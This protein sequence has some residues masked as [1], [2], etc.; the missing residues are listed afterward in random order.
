[1]G[2]CSAYLCHNKSTKNPDK[3]YFVLPKDPKI[4]NAWIKA[5][6]RTELPKNVC[7]CSDHFED[8]CFDKSWELQNRLFYQGR[9]QKRKLLPGSIP[10]IFP[11]KEKQAERS[12][13]KLRAK[14]KESFQ[15]CIYSKTTYSPGPFL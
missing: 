6:N 14:K 12:I 15:V 1:M 9:I 4:R 10:T 5:I 2:C 13:S 11:H 7:V 8:G 3:S